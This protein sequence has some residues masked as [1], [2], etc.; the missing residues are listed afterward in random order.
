MP[1]VEIAQTPGRRRA[2]SLPWWPQ[3]AQRWDSPAQATAWRDLAEVIASR[4]HEP[5]G[6]SRTI[7]HRIRL[8]D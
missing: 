8:P 4:V 5:I 1:G 3:P 6:A 7:G 2:R